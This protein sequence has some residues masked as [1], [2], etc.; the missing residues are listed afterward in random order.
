MPGRTHTP[1]FKSKVALAAIRDGR[2]VVEPARQFD[3]HPN[4][5]MCW[6]NQLLERA[7]DQRQGAAREN[8]RTH[9]TV[10]PAPSA[11]SHVSVLIA[12][13]AD[14]SCR[15]GLCYGHYMHPDAQRLRVPGRRDGR[16]LAQ[17]PGRTGIHH[18]GCTL[19]PGGHGGSDYPL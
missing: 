10:S 18:S 5:I 4:R 6:K 11:A 8:W 7:A 15:A 12:P 2:T 19:L 3:L 14:H 13:S 1:A 17:G 16:V 9:T